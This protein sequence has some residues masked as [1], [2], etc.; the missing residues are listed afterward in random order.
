MAHARKRRR[1]A[2]LRDA[3]RVRPPPLYAKRPG[4]RQS[5]GALLAGT[6][7]LSTSTKACTK[8]P[9]AQKSAPPKYCLRFALPSIQNGFLPTNGTKHTNEERNGL[10]ANAKSA[11]DIPPVPGRDVLPTY[12]VHLSV[13]LR[14][15]CGSNMVNFWNRVR[16]KTA[17]SP[18]M[19]V[20]NII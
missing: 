7:G 5:S 17:N 10:T 16:K 3:P 8:P 15:C 11:K 9:E 18:K 14:K 4:V 2:A 12:A 13:R 6:N 20:F 19:L 1:A